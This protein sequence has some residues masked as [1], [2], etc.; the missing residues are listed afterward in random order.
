MKKDYKITDPCYETQ[1]VK[2]KHKD[3]TT[4]TLDVHRGASN[5]CYVYIGDERVYFWMDLEDG[6]WLEQM[7]N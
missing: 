6:E 7:L 3:G 4:E 1:T 2:Y 5:D